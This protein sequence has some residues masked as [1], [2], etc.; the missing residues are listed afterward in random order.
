MLLLGL[1]MSLSSTKK[2]IWLIVCSMSMACC[3]SGVCVEVLSHVSGHVVLLYK[4]SECVGGVAC[5][6]SISRS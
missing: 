1:P 4:A 5:P 6:L 3:E 2:I